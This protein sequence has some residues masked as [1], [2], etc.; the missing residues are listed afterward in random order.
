MINAHCSSFKWWNQL[1][2]YG[3]QKR[4]LHPTD[5]PRRNKSTFSL[6]VLIL[7]WRYRC[8]FPISNN[9]S[10]NG[11]NLQRPK[12]RREAKKKTKKIFSADDV[13]VC[14]EICNSPIKDIDTY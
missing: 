7:D 5:C 13:L 11:L 14:V 9:L 6:G 1:L 12:H 2:I 4:N 3:S 8:G 10:T